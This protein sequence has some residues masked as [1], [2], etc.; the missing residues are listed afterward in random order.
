VRPVR[1]QRGL[2]IKFEKWKI[3]KSR[4]SAVSVSHVS[5]PAESKIYFSS[6]S[7][8]TGRALKPLSYPVVIK[9]NSSGRKAAMCIPPYAVRM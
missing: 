7:V 4:D 6:I 8:H 9:G 3:E 5:I 1:G 2:E